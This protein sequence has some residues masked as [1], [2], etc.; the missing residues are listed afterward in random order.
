MALHRAAR[1]GYTEDVEALLLEYPS[2]L[3]ARHGRSQWTPLM[4]AARTGQCYM[5]EMLLSRGAE[6]DAVD[7]D[8]YT[9]LQLAAIYG[10]AEVVSILLEKGAGDDGRAL[11]EA[12]AE[13]FVS[14]VERIV[15]HSGKEL[16]KAGQ[17]AL[18]CA[19]DRGHRDII[20]VLLLAGADPDV[21]DEWGV[22][23]RETARNYDS[24]FDGYYCL[25]VIDVSPTL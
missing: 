22:T 18:W 14:V 21:Q 11:I 9:A 5:V 17:T 23:A 1:H 20:K 13:G 25:A 12:T 16:G 7:I 24:F 3:E 4:T 10:R 6:I 8:G 2:L 15:E 19:C